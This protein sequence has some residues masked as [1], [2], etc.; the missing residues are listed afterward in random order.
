MSALLYLL[1][2]MTLS[3]T[4]CNNLTSKISNTI[5]HKL[6]LPKT[7]PNNCIFSNLEY[8]FF[9]LWDRQLLLHSTR[10]TE[11]INNSNLAGKCA[12]IALQQYQNLAWTSTCVTFKHFQWITLNR[13]KSL[14]YDILTMLRLQE[15]FFKNINTIT[16]IKEIDTTL[17][18]TMGEK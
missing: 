3:E 16:T 17:E 4:K 14:T 5:K 1:N 6:S 2:N 8:G 11:R 13:R 10:W 15:I 18:N 7:A 12:R 9:H